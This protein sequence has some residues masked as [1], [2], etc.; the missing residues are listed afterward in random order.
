[1]EKSMVPTF[2]ALNVGGVEFTVEG[3]TVSFKE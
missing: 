3:I 2:D 1:M